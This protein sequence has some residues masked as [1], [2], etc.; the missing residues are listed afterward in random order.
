MK[1]DLAYTLHK[2]M[3]EQLIVPSCINC[4]HWA[5]T[6]TGG[7]LLFEGAQPPPGIVVLGCEHWEPDIPF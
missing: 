1:R 3:V 5:P 4:E 2:E 6:E 7:C